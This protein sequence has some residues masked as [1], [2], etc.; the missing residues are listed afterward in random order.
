[1]N[2]E[3]KEDRE[4]LAW[5]DASEGGESVLPPIDPARAET[6]QRMQ[7][8]IASLPEL[9]APDDGWE[10]KIY[11]E[12]DRQERLERNDDASRKSQRSIA[13]LNATTAAQSDSEKAKDEDGDKRSASNHRLVPVTR[14]SDAKRPKRQ[15]VAIGSTAA[16]LAAVAVGA[17]W[18]KGREKQPIGELADGETGSPG[19]SSVPVVVANLDFR[20]VAGPEARRS[21]SDSSSEGFI[22]D[23]LTMGATGGSGELRVYLEG[24]E[25]IRSC[26]AECAK[27]LTDGQ[28]RYEVTFPAKKRGEYRAYFI[29]CKGSSGSLNTDLKNCKGGWKRGAPILIR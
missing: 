2:D 21:T 28:W 6:Y 19:Q 13:L 7:L 22:E 27:A 29:A 24:K 23:N 15:W 26:A 14:I 8:E 18:I 12:L 25:L 9:T 17:V 5:L 10:D 4:D 11:D 1:M 16:A 3:R 20:I